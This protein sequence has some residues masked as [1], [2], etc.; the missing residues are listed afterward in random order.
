[1]VID[2]ARMRSRVYVTVER[3]SVCL[4][5]RSTAATAA[6]GFAAERCAG[7]RCRST[8][9]YAGA[10]QRMRVASL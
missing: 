7:K 5:R 1:M 2:A 9:A 8:V 6:G 3:P 4:S 10:Q